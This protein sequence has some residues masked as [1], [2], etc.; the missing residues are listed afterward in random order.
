MSARERVLV[1]FEQLT[2]EQLSELIGIFG[3]CDPSDP[4]DEDT[5][6]TLAEVEYMKRHPEE[7]KSYSSAEEMLA[8]ILGEDDI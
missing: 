4:L 7:Y 8:D 5:F 3:D 1:F 6:E 2:E